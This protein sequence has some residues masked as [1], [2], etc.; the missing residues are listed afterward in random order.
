MRIAFFVDA[1]PVLSE[2]FILNQI[3]GLVDRGHEVD[4]YARG[5]GAQNIV[6]PEVAKYRLGERVF[7]LS[8]IPKSVVGRIRF[9]FKTLVRN[10]VFTTPSCWMQIQYIFMSPRVPGV[11][12]KLAQLEVM[13]RQAQSKPY[14]IIHSQ[15]GTLGR[16]L[17]SLKETGLLPGKHITSF[18]GHDIT[19]HANS[20]RGFYDELF[21]KGDLFL[22]VSNSLKQRLVSRGCDEEKIRILHSGINCERFICQEKK[23]EK[24]EPVNILTIARL[25]E[26]KGVKYGIQAV[27]RLVRS[28]KSIHYKIAGDGVLR[29]ELENLIMELGMDRSIQLLGWKDHDNIARL[30]EHAHIL[31]TPSITAANGEQEGIPNVVKEAMAMGI[32][33]CSTFHSG[34][35]ELLENGVSGYLAPERDADLLA[36]CLAKLIDYSEGWPEMGRSGRKKVEEEFEMNKLNDKLIALYRSMVT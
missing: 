28:G 8:D 9:L 32:P 1:F 13:L 5:R 21:A 15:Y 25:V 14:E 31:M 11:L 35:P 29:G 10:N 30:M 16:G 36:E 4:I 27:A 24:D 7:Y 3:T 22:P 20:E 26:M 23:L 33:V 19:Q 6:H 34:I 18:R 17:I 2:T 12:P